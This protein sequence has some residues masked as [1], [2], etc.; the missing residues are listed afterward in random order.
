MTQFAVMERRKG[1]SSVTMEIRFPMMAAHVAVKQNIAVMGLDKA[2]SGP[3]ILVNNV[4][5]VAPQ[6]GPSW[7]TGVTRIAVHVHVAAGVLFKGV[8]VYVDL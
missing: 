3:G 7:V 4:M 6:V 1:R 2:V 8:A 5:M